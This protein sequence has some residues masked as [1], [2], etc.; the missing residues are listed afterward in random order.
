MLR[1][2]HSSATNVAASSVSTGEPHDVETCGLQGESVRD[3]VRSLLNAE[4]DYDP[5][6]ELFSRPLRRLGIL[7]NKLS[8]LRKWQRACLVRVEER[9]IAI[10]DPTGLKRI[11]EHRQSAL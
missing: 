7:S 1:P 11:S 6:A 2:Q 9:S 10:V 8:C 3:P 4:V 5:S